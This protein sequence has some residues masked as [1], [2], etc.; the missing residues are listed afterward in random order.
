MA[1]SG[2]PT[3][4]G[5]LPARCAGRRRSRA[6]GEG[7]AAAA[8][9]RDGAEQR[10][11]PARPSERSDPIARAMAATSGRR[12]ASGRQDAHRLVALEGREDQRAAR[13]RRSSGRDPVAGSSVGTPATVACS[14]DETCSIRSRSGVVGGVPAGTRSGASAAVPTD[15][16]GTTT[17]PASRA[18]WS[19]GDGVEPLADL[20]VDRL[21]AARRP[22]PSRSR[23]ASW[24]RTRRSTSGRWAS[25]SNSSSASIRPWIGDEPR[26]TLGERPGSATGHDRRRPRADARRGSSPPKRPQDRDPDGERDET[27]GDREQGS[28]GGDYTRARLG[29]AASP[30]SGVVKG[31]AWSLAAVWRHSHRE[32]AQAGLFH[33]GMT[34]YG[35][36]PT[37]PGPWTS[38]P[39]ME[40]PEGTSTTRGR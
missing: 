24:N 29:R 2:S 25:S 31:A 7:V 30:E 13:A 39:G 8:V 16:R 34:P 5:S 14:T 35:L 9:P 3:R 20:E 23:S 21:G 37:T 15:S 36:R 27:D 38:G 4:P 12:G 40:R 28:H 19:I 10:P 1:V 11:R 6:L 32:Y 26:R 18:A 22:S 33:P 17:R